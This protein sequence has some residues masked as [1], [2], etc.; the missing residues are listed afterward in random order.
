MVENKSRFD[1]Y[2]LME[3]DDAVEYVKERL[4]YFEDNSNLE[5]TEIG[6]GNLNYVFKI[7]DKNSNK[8]LILKHSGEDTRAKS[9]RKLNID[10]NIKECKII[11]MQ[12]ELC[13]GYVPEIY[14]YDEVMNCYAMEDLSSYEI[15]RKAL[16]K[17][18]IFPHFADKITTF[19]VDTLLPTTDVVLNHKEKKDMV[20]KYTNIEL[21]D[22]SEQLV[23]TEPAGNF[24]K[25][26][27]VVAPLEAFVKETIYNDKNFRL[28]CAKLKFNFMNNAQ[29]LIHGDL[30]SGSLFIDENDIKVI[31]PE[32]AFYG[33][34]GYDVGNII[35]NLMMAWANGIATIEDSDKRDEFTSW[36]ENCC[37]DIVDLFKEKFLEKFDKEATDLLAK[38]EGF[39]EYY[40]DGILADT[41]GTAGMELIRRIIGIAKVEDLTC[42]QDIEKRAKV[43]EILISAGK[44]FVINREKFKTGAQYI[45]TLKKY[46][47]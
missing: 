36:I 1:E 45:E 3:E 5:C 47:K 4:D 22:I 34:M 2:F 12:G 24:L 9:G 7:V 29:A 37:M 27:T 10:R 20:K 17:H 21:C 6:D 33:P 39:K 46:M 30:H 31:D 15:M 44:D 43:E 32:F 25:E 11:K 35:A 40:L 41:A 38:A 13:P 16:V 42:I 28:E 23:F 26:N 19:M 14:M 18:K 8:S